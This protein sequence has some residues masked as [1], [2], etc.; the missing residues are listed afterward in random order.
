MAF[1]PNDS[2][3]PHAVDLGPQALYAK[4]TISIVGLKMD[5]HFKLD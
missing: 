3:D 1:G 4:A 5:G 2:C